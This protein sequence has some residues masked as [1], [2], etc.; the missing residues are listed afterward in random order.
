[1]DGKLRFLSLVSTRKPLVGEKIEWPIS[2]LH[3]ALPH[4]PFGQDWDFSWR[5]LCAGLVC[6]DNRSIP[7]GYCHVSCL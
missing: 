7:Q 4:P 3:N 6:G 2:G 5:T 1:M